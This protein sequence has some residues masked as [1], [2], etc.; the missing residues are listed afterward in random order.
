LI[1]ALF[2]VAVWVTTDNPTDRWVALGAVGQLSAAV[3]AAAAAL[4][5]FM[6]VRNE[7]TRSRKEEERSRKEEKRSLEDH[8]HALED[9]ERALKDRERM[10]SDREHAKNASSLEMLLALDKHFNEDR[11]LRIRSRAAAS[12]LEIGSDGMLQEWPDDDV[13]EIQD[14][15]NFFDRIAFLTKCEALNKEHVWHTYGPRIC[16]YYMACKD[17]IKDVRSKR[18]SPWRYEQLEDLHKTL[19]DIQ[20]QWLLEREGESEGY[21]A[22]HLK[23][24][25]QREVKR[26]SDN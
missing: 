3:A 4:C 8:K 23:H 16:L 25:L 24:F 26:G 1:V 22:E 12:L 11:F 14:V 17:G 19:F 2:A 10:E 18:S 6:T 9:R 5:A 21:R 15:L 7:E 13:V 20:Q